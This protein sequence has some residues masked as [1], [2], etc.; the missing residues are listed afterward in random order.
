M[1]ATAGPKAPARDMTGRQDFD[2]AIVGAGPTGVYLANMLGRAGLRVMI[3]DRE[4]AILQM[5]R[6]VHFDGEIMRA[7]Q[8]AGL[9]VSIARIARASSQGMHFLSATGKTLMVRRGYEGVGPH[10]WANN[11]DAHQP[12]LEAVLREG[13]SRFPAA[14]TRF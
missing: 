12:H 13:L 2:V 8:A 6:A 3:A 5:P 9:A 10:G 4:A 14:E 1:P 7:F 11:Y